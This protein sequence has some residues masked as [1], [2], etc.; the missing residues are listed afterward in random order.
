M[1]Q[2]VSPEKRSVT[3]STFAVIPYGQKTLGVELGATDTDGVLDGD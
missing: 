2:E 1:S 3:I